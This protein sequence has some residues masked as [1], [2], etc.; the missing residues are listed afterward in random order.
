MG[1]DKRTFEERLTRAVEECGKW[2]T[3]HAA[4]IVG[5]ADWR[6]DLVIRVNLIEGGCVEAPTITVER[7]H[8]SRE[9]TEA[10]W[11]V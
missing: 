6:T 11:N 3:E 9:A 10:Y 1:E 4:D 5:E 2:I 7:T 8:I